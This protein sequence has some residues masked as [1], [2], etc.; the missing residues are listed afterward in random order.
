MTADEFVEKL[1]RLAPSLESL[2][3]YGYSDSGGVEHRRLYFLQKKPFEQPI[4]D[5]PLIQLISNYDTSNFDF[6]LT[7]GKRKWD[8]SPPPGKVHV[9][10]VEADILVINPDTGNV[11]LL[12]HGHPERVLAKCA[13]SGEQFLEA[14]LLL[15]AYEPPYPGLK[16]K[17]NTKQL[18]VNN[19]AAKKRAMECAKVA[20]ISTPP[21]IYAYLL[22]CDPL[23]TEAG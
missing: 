2:R 18:R 3:S 15:V 17:L 8:F 10:A 12:D 9:G 23:I 13:A 16:H 21:N 5:D 4:Y 11:E 20:G 7:L 1:A 6:G 19:E 14:L 22:G